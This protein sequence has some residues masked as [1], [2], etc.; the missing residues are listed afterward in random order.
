MEHYQWQDAAGGYLIR[1]L[2]VHHVGAVNGPVA[3]GDLR[4]RPRASISAGHRLRP[5]SRP[6]R[7]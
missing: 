3:L 2:S 7:R 5:R 4:P 1:N 6:A